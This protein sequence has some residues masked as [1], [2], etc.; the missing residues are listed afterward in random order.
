MQ[1]LVDLCERYNLPHV[2]VYDW[3]YTLPDTVES[4]IEEVN[5]KKSAIDGGMIEGFVIY[6]QE[7][8]TSYKCVSPDFLLKYH[9]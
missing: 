4:L 6:S 8:N 1:H 9:G 5:K 7:G 3:G 2:H